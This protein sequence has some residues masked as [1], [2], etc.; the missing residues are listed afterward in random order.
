MDKNRSSRLLSALLL[1]TS[2]APASRM[3]AE[4]PAAWRP[5]SPPG[6][7]VGTLVVDPN[8][9]GAFVAT[10]SLG[11]W[12]STDRAAT[13]VS[14]IDTTSTAYVPRFEQVSL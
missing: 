6:S 7:A 5:A 12:R 3:V 10:T 8:E 9:A 2:L 1:L 4:P 13:W 11:L 14:A